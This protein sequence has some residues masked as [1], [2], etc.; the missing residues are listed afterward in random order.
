MAGLPNFAETAGAEQFDQLPIA[1][2]RR[3]V[4]RL[5]ARQPLRQERQ[6]VFRSAQGACGRQSRA[7]L[8]GGGA[9]RLAYRARHLAEIRGQRDLHLGR[10]IGS[11]FAD[12]LLRNLAG[13]RDGGLRCR[14]DFVAQLLFLVVTVVIRQ[15]VSGGVIQHGAH[16]D[17]ADEARG[18]CLMMPL[19]TQ[20][21]K[22]RKPDMDGLR[23]QEKAY[24]II[25]RC[26]TPTIIRKKPPERRQI[27]ASECRTRLL[28]PPFSCY[29]PP[30]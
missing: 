14:L 28:P 21:R 7:G 1:D 29:H 10:L 19:P 18:P 6:E 16:R 27:D 20:R 23:K 26:S 25:I 2:A 4:A 12:D 3:A 24:L 9:Q 15:D 13:F 22:W 17:E 8:V 11:D 30:S 5:E